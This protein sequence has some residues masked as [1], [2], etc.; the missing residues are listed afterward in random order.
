MYD[1]TF[2]V[3]HVTDQGGQVIQQGT[4]LD[5]DHFNKIEVG[6]SDTDLAHRI[7]MIKNI[8]ESY[9]LSPEVQTFALGMNDLPWPF[10]NKEHSVGLKNL[11]N[12][13]NYGVDIEVVSYSGGQIGSFEILG[14]AKNGFKI[15]HN[16]SATAVTVTIRV[17]G[18]MTDVAV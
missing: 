7:M 6:V 16:G 12:N 3:N 5:Q 2:W 8:Q 4:L 11:R 13:T 18:G 9:N 14:R 10:N 1:R 15:L 17:T